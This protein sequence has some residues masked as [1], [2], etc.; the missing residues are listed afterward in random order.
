SASFRRAVDLE[1]EHAPAWFNLARQLEQQ[2][3]LDEAMAG[4]RRAEAICARRSDELSGKWRGLAKAAA[5]KL[6]PQLERMQERLA[7]ARGARSADPNEPV[8]AAVLAYR[9]GEPVLSARTY[10]RAFAASPALLGTY[11][12]RYDAACSAA[13]AGTRAGG[14]ASRPSDDELAGLRQQA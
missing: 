13:L 5:D 2:G 7:L 11:P 6:A 14:A 8:A 10:A 12:Y 1:P 3:R 9:R 4:Y